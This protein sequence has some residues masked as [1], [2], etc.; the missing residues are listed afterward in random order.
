VNFVGLIYISLTFLWGSVAVWAAVLF[1]TGFIGAWLT[2]RITPEWWLNLVAGSQ[3]IQI[4][5]E[6]MMLALRSMSHICAPVNECEVTVNVQLHA[7]NAGG[8]LA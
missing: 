4:G 2:V 6:K 5:S 8:A 7:L 3:T 1:A